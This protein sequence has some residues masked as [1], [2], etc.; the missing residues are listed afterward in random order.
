MSVA[1]ALEKHNGLPGFN[2][3]RALEIAREKCPEAP[4][5]PCIPSVAYRP[6]LNET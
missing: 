3:K 6:T 4:A 2:G 1:L 5:D